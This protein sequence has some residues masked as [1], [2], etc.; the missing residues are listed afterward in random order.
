MALLSALEAHDV[1]KAFGSFLLAL[2]VS[3]GPSLK[4]VAPRPL[5]STNGK[6]AAHFRVWSWRGKLG[7]VV[8]RLVW[9]IS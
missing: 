2:L 8:L 9:G 7:F 4:C 5:L 1:S 3:K 6:Q